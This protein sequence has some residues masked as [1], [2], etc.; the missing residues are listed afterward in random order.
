MIETAHAGAGLPTSV[1]ELH[2]LFDGQRRA[3]RNGPP[4]GLADRRRHLA[5]LA[6]VVVGNRRRIER[7][8]RD[9]FGVHHDALTDLTEVLGVA[10]Q[11]QYVVERLEDWMAPEVREVD[12]MAYG[13]ASAVI[14][15]HPKGV[16]GI[17]SPWNL[18]FLLSLGPLVDALAAGN[19][20]LV[21]P[22]E[23]TPASASLLREMIGAAFDETVVAVVCGEVDLAREFTALP[24]DHLLYTGSTRI[25]REVALAAARNLVPLT[26]ELGGKNPVV[27]A[28]DSVDAETVTQVLGSKLAKSGQICIAPDYCYVPRRDVDRFVELAREYVAGLGDYTGS[29]ECAS[30]LADAHADRL[31]L[32]VDEAGARGGR[33][34]VLGDEGS[35]ASE[36]RMP[37]HLVLDPPQDCRLMEEEI[38]GPVLPVVPY[39]DL[40][41]VVED[42]GRREDP[43][44][45]YVFSQDLEL[46]R[47]IIA[48]TRS[49]G[50]CVNTC[51]VQGVLPSLGFGGVGASGYGRHRGI[52]GFR[53]FSVARG[54]VVRGSTGD[55]IHA[56]FPP[57]SGLAQAIADGALGSADAG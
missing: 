5:T 42:L 3:T 9:D 52:E 27:I 41:E 28:H 47:S 11:A 19:R 31:R 21:K 15:H 18:P 17:V 8:L 57:Y 16:V 23:L 29:G 30:L 33:V 2:R 25:G 26:L 4:P 36:R 44:G 14:E 49:G 37:P 51:V 22:S 39:D 55:A 50:A 13:T 35:W 1:E 6:E 40:E 24:W 54:V 56:M 7:A 34:V 10:G 12:P 32:L 45:L 48:R 43:L 46:A 53:E 20:A 38:F